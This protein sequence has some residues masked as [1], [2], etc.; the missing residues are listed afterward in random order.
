MTNIMRT[1]ISNSIEIFGKT[2]PDELLPE[3]TDELVLFN[4]DALFSTLKE[5]NVQTIILMGVLSTSIIS[6]IVFGLVHF[7][8]NADKDLTVNVIIC[9]DVTV[10]ICPD[11]Y[12]RAISGTFPMLGASILTCNEAVDILRGDDVETFNEHGK[13][14]NT[15]PLGDRRLDPFDFQAILRGA[16]VFIP[17]GVI[18]DLYNADVLSVDEIYEQLKVA[19]G[20][21]GT[22]IGALKSTIMDMTCVFYFLAGTFLLV[23]LLPT[24][25]IYD[26]YIQGLLV[27]IGY[28]VPSTIYCFSTPLNEWRAMIDSELKVQRFKHSIHKKATEYESIK[29]KNRISVLAKRETTFVSTDFLQVMQY[30]EEVIFSGKPG[31]IKTELLYIVRCAY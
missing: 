12:E 27:F 8:P 20:Y 14:N 28:F 9:S 18:V 3:F 31:T 10:G 30:I 2:I 7:F 16:G 17:S 21:R 23:G 5:K 4:K 1:T 24:G 22:R 13:H 6:D 29:V 15:T 19:G 11:E 26:H 25:A